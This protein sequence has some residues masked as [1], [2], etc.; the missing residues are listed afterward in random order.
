M[1]WEKTAVYDIEIM[2]FVDTTI[3]IQHGTT[4]IQFVAML[5]TGSALLFL[6]IVALSILPAHLRALIS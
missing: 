1:R 2:H 4:K 6:A 3:Q 5:E